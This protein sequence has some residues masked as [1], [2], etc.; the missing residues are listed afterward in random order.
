M[1]G[2]IRISLK[3]SIWNSMYIMNLSKQVFFRAN[4]SILSLL[5]CMYSE[6]I[7]Y[8]VPCFSWSMKLPSP[9]TIFQ[10]L[11]G[12]QPDLK[13]VSLTSTMYL[14]VKLNQI[15]TL[16]GNFP[17]VNQDRKQVIAMKLG[18]KVFSYIFH[19]TYQTPQ[20]L[21]YILFILILS[22]AINLF[23]EYE[24]NQNTRRQKKLTATIKKSDLSE[25]S[26]LQLV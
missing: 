13:Y 6:T 7:F 21:T 4:I 11:L 10:F 20:L 18:P 9:A 22:P 26:M 25:I 15:L 24:L 16:I 12:F 23:K 3:E 5:C 19:V 14:Q 1:H 17:L 2:K 8:P